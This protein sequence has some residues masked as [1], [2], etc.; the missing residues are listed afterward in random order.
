MFS[1]FQPAGALSAGGR[2]SSTGVEYGPDGQGSKTLQVC[3]QRPGL[4]G[5]HH[6]GGQLDESPDFTTDWQG[7]LISTAVSSLERSSN[8]ELIIRYLNSLLLSGEYINYHNADVH[9]SLRY[10]L[11]FMIKVKSND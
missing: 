11:Y 7:K 2:R 9:L 4:S 8:F 6:C 10:S 3:H 1:Y 5:H